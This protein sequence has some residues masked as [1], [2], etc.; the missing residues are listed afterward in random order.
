MSSMYKWLSSIL[1][2]LYV[3]W[4]LSLERGWLSKA[5]LVSCSEY[6][7]PRGSRLGWGVL[8]SAFWGRAGVQLGYPSQQYQ[9]LPNLVYKLCTT[10]LVFYILSYSVFITL[11]SVAFN[12][13]LLL[14]LSP[15]IISSHNTL[16]HDPPLLK[17]LFCY[18][19]SFKPLHLCHLSYLSHLPHL[20]IHSTS[21]PPP[22]PPGPFIPFSSF[23]FY[24]TLCSITCY[25]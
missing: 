21:P 6:T 22:L 12:I 2:V 16:S 4:R 1:H 10:I 18:F 20:S 14:L 5:L 3:L 17:P 24:L 23:S 15:L 7:T 11:W 13:L 25:D 19:I 9:K 8:L